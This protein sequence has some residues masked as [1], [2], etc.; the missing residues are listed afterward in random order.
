MMNDL[1]I[2]VCEMG[3][4]IMNLTHWMETLFTKVIEVKGYEQ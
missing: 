1:L 4:T 2:V 3:F